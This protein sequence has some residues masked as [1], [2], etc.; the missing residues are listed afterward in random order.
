MPRVLLKRFEV[1][2]YITKGVPSFSGSPF[3]RTLQ[4]SV[5]AMKK[6]YDRGPPVKFP[7]QC[8]R[9]DEVCRKGLW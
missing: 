2:A 4:L 8:V 6:S 3:L 5:L 9:E 7:G 1:T